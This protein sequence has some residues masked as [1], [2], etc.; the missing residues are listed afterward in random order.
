MILPVMVKSEPSKMIF[1]LVSRS[2]NVKWLSHTA[3]DCKGGGGGG[4]KFMITCIANDR[5]H[6]ISKF[7]LNCL[8]FISISLKCFISL[9]IPCLWSKS[10]LH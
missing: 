10:K 9:V 4:V 2:I 1:S 6:F 7:Y 3:E 5:D 8:P